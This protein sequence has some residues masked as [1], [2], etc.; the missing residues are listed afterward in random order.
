M[1]MQKL[2]SKQV[3]QVIAL[4]VI[5]V[6]V[7]GYAV[8]TF[9]GSG[10]KPSPSKSAA[11]SST[12][13]TASTPETGASSAES[14]VAGTRMALSVAEAGGDPAHPAGGSPEAAPGI[15]LPGQYNPDPFKA[16]M[17]P[18]PPVKAVQVTPK[19][20]PAPVKPKPAPQLPDAS[21]KGPATTL[22]N[23]I[24]PPPAAPERPAVRVT[25]TSVTD[26]MNLAILEI[27]PEHR[28]VQV[29]DVVSK[30]YRVK[31]IQLQGVVFVKDKDHFFQGVGAKSD[32]NK[33]DNAQEKSSQ[34]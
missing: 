26:G 29:G 34:L 10:P 6:G 25:G 18:E 15:N 2:D 32:P 21:L 3:P 23:P 31:K 16:T 27:G 11:K 24:A 20:A 1:K 9:A 30:G 13:A 19:P 4:S 12:S 33:P 14:S 8:F 22:I 28:V 5:S 7:F 17:K